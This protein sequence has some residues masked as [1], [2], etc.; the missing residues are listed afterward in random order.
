MNLKI[1]NFNL[2]LYT[3]TIMLVLC[4][5][6]LVSGV[7]LAMHYK[8]DFELAFGSVSNTIM[9]EVAYG[10]LW[11]KIHAMGSTFLFLLLYI[12]MLGMLYFGFYKHGKTKYW[13][14][15]MALYFCFMV[16]GFTGYVLPMGQMSYWAVQVITSLLAYIPGAGE[17][18]ML[19]VRGDFSVSEITLLRF[20]ALHIVVMPLCI[21]SIVLFH[22][23]FFKWH[24]THKLSLTRKGLHISK[25]DR[26]SKTLHADAK[27][28]KPFFSNAVLKPLLACSLFLALFFYCVFFHDY[29]ALDALNATPANPSDT[30][31]HIYPEW[32]FLWMLQLLKSFFFDIGMI[33]GSY[34]GMASLVVVNGGLLLMPLLDKNP[35][36]IPAHQR[37]Y[38][39]GWF[40]AL[41]VCLVA[42][43]ILGKLPSTSL[44]LWMGLFFSSVLLGL[45][46]VLPFLSQKESH[47]KS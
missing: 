43:S 26:F 1:N 21:V 8:P 28:P 34:I 38:F 17:D 47:A 25:E 29:L 14:N 12:H 6:M 4:I 16:I 45:F 10:W 18:I 13:F 41:V 2:L 9:N 32:Y 23:D 19:W 30:P 40:W 42:L 39:F 31:A 15:G 35:R 3:G 36:R 33:K 7:F 22:A 44:T 27:A 20:Y 46:F 11:R 5:L 37:P 24:A